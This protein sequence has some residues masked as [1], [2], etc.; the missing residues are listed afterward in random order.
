MIGAAA[1]GANR[2]WAWSIP[3]R[4]AATQI[5]GMYGSMTTTSQSETAR[6]ASGEQENQSEQAHAPRERDHARPRRAGR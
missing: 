4:I 1:H 3:P 6:S 2:P 5:K